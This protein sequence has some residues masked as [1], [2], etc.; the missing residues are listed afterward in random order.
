M[1]QW[2]L[3]V[4]RTERDPFNYPYFGKV[5]YF[6]VE[7]LYHGFKLL[8]HPAFPGPYRARFIA[9]HDRDAMISYI[10]LRYGAEIE[11]SYSV[12]SLP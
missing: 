12:I 5:Q 11:F 10:A 7:L 6:R 4:H 9:A 2:F 1:N 3:Q 8:E